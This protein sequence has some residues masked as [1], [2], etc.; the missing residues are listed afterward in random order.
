MRYNE[1]LTRYKSKRQ[2]HIDHVSRIIKIARMRNKEVPKEV[3]DELEFTK[4]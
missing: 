2:K 3:L 4:R 1:S